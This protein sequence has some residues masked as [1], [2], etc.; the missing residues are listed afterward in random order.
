[1]IPDRRPPLPQGLEDLDRRFDDGVR[2]RPSLAD[3][4]NVLATLVDFDLVDGDVNTD[5]LDH[6]SPLMAR[7]VIPDAP[8]HE[9]PSQQGPANVLEPD[10]MAGYISARTAAFALI[11]AM[12]FGAASAAF[13]FHERLSQIVVQ[14]Q[15]GRK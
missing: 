9:Q 1:M 5:V 3:E 15:T 7:L 14:W 12:F 10:E 2:V 6:P 4:P 8:P 13:V 11:L